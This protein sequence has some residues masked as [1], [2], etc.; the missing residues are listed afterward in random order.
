MKKTI[1]TVQN[2]GDMVNLHNHNMNHIWN[3]FAKQ[4]KTNSNLKLALFAV[5]AYAFITDVQSKKMEA[6]IEELEKK[7]D[8]LTVLEDE[9]KGE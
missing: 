4:A 5:A 8:E 2:L 1:I 3:N 9:E 6:R 7:L